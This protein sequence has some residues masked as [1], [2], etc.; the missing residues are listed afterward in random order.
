MKQIKL[1]VGKTYR[2]RRGEEVK[3]VEKQETVGRHAYRG[4]DDEWYT[5]RGRFN[6]YVGQSGSDLIEEV[7]SETTRHTFVIPDGVKEITLSYE[8][9]PLVVEM[10]PEAKEPKPGDAAERCRIMD[11]LQGYANNVTWN[12][13]QLYWLI[14][15][16]LM[17][18]E[19][20]K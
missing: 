10:V 15:G 20:K 3:I 5:E 11:Y 4:S 17:R 6:L 8:G 19:D 1:E 13:E 9:K 14:E 18:K 7:P 16:Y 12:H 2:N